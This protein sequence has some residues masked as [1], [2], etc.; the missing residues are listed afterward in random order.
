MSLKIG[1]FGFGRTGS[2]VA[3]EITLDPDLSLEWICRKTTTQNASFA[4]H[5][6]GYSK[7]FAPFVTADSLNEKFLELHPVDLIIDFSSSS[8]SHIYR[9]LANCGIKIVSAISHYEMEELNLL[10]EASSKTSVL[11]S[12][13]ITLG[14]NWLIMASKVLRKIIPHADVEVIEEHFRAKKDV[15]GT[16][17]KL[18]MQLDIDPNEHVNSIRVGGIVGKHEVIFGLPHQTIRIT[19]ESISRAAFGT[20]AIFAAKW[21]RTQN[22][23]FYSMENVLQDTFYKKMNEVTLI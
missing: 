4:S 14:I 1:L 3:K 21:L 12:P 8:T 15:S 17:L 5:Y 2:V 11:Y 9:Q 18:A 19:H 23:G 13:N 16:A 7:D 22:N 20:G 6:L 10:K